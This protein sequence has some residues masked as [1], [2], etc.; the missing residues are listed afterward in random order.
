[1]KREIIPIKNSQ[2][3]GGECETLC[4][5]A[6]EGI[7]FSLAC[8]KLLCC[9]SKADQDCF[10]GSESAERKVERSKGR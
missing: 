6:W 10:S 4:I 3:C 8:E 5:C 2:I 7:M 9:F 1:M